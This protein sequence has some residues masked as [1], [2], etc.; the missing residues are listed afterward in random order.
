MGNGR[1]ANSSGNQSGAD[2]R[3]IVLRDPNN[4]MG[5]SSYRFV[6][7][8]PA[9]TNNW[10]D[11]DHIS[12][13]N[14]MSNPNAP[15]LI[16]RYTLSTQC[17]YAWTGEIDMAA[18]DGSNTVWRFAHNHN[19]GL[20]CYYGQGFAEISNDGKWALFSSYWDGTLGSDTSFGCS[21]RIDTFIIDLTGA[22]S[23]T[24]STGTTTNTTPTSTTPP[25]STSAPTSGTTSPGTSST[26]TSSSSA[27]S[28]SN[29]GF[30]VANNTYYPISSADLQSALDCAPLGSTIVLQTAAPYVGS[31]QLPNKTSGSGWITVTSQSASLPAA[32]VRVSPSDVTAGRLAQIQVASGRASPV[33]FTAAAA[34]HYQ[35]IGIAF[36]TPQWVQTLVQLGSGAETATS[37]LPHHL[38]F[39]RCLFA[40]SASSGTKHGLIAN[41]GQGSVF[42]DD[43]ITI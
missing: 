29:P 18:T 35:F 14:S 7:Q 17:N 40:G 43:L 11:A 16:S 13:L 34:H 20:V 38:T 6:Y 32:G 41:A 9:P 3:G 26:P 25:T 8:P 15:I 22:S 31:F 36:S 19:G 10:C 2:S 4:L 23:S 21:S 30:T 42:S 12:W 24:G 1:Y 39:D 37:Q 33:V 5:S 27:T 28:C